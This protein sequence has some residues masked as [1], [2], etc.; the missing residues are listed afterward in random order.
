M[1]GLYFG[2]CYKIIFDAVKTLVEFGVQQRHPGC[3]SSVYGVQGDRVRA[4]GL[5]F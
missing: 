3:R 2:S 5:D 4:L 1:F